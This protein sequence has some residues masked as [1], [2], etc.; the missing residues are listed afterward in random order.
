M[1]IKHKSRLASIHAIQSIRAACKLL[2]ALERACLHARCGV[3]APGAVGTK[4]AEGEENQSHESGT[5]FGVDGR[6]LPNGVHRMGGRANVRAIRGWKVKEL[7]AQGSVL[8]NKQ[9]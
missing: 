8:D 4:N 5:F 3:W 2:G 6:R 9:N 7:D 1:V